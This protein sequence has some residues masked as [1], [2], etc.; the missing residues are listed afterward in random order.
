MRNIGLRLLFIGLIFAYVLVLF[1]DIF[2]VI[3]YWI[4][5]GKEVWFFISKY[6]FEAIEE[7]CINIKKDG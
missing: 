3:I 2:I 7:I 4:W 1:I 5:S 6:I